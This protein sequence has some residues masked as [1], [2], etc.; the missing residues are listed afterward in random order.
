MLYQ[1]SLRLRMHLYEAGWLKRIKLPVPVLVVGNVMVGGAGKTPVTMELAAQLQEL[2]WRI[3]ILS[4]GYGRASDALI[5]VNKLS[6]ASQVG[7]EPLLIHQRTGLPV[8]VG[9]DRVRAGLALLRAH[10][11]INLLICDDG[12][13]HLKLW[14]DAALCVFDPRRTGNGWTL[15]AGP[16]REPWPLLSAAPYVWTL[17]S[18]EPPWS[19][20]WPVIRRLSDLAR[21]GQGDQILLKDL[22]QPVH[23][24][25]GIAQPERFFEAL[26]AA[27]VPLAQTRALPDHAALNDW[28]PDAA[29]TWLCTE[30]DAVKLRD[31]CPEVWAVPLQVSLPTDLIL[32]IDRALRSHRALRSV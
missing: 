24:M 11:E 7:D 13:Q 1:A 6:S 3:G 32:Q 15:P 9:R 19:G 22:P 16:L 14:H 31:S 30:K 17:S 29:G 21:N 12:M 2:G 20:A 8:M 27:G 4:R 10:P 5:E 25:A 28:R 18:E 26:R 23:A